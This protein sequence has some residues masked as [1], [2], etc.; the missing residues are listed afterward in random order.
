MVI[1][2]I[3]TTKRQEKL[4]NN[5]SEE[6]FTSTNLYLTCCCVLIWSFDTMLVIN[7]HLKSI[8][9]T[10]LFNFRPT[11]KLFSRLKCD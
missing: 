4:P 6:S 2:M 1:M 11:A 9:G 10:K 7:L 8:N 3:I 5:D